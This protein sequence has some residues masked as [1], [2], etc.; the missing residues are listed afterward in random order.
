MK[1]VKLK[2]K[3]M[4][5]LIENP[6]IKAF[7]DMIAWAEGTSTCMQTMDDG[8]DIEV[9]G[10]RFE[11][12]AEHPFEHRPPLLINKAKN[13]RS[14]A[15]GRYQILRRFWDHYAIIYGLTD[16]S[17]TSQDIV[18][19]VMIRECKAY[20]DIVSG[21]IEAAIKKCSSRWASLPGNDYQQPKKRLED[22]V[23]VWEGYGGSKRVEPVIVGQSLS[24]R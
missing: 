13:L 14:T 11:S 10:S 18:C 22:L 21:R 9:G 8:Y 15:A 20:G 3:D 24:V 19:V 23:N 12:Y 7:M 6:N 17:P 4:A 1:R 2:A 16:F 5:R